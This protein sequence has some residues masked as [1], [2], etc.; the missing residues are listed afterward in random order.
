MTHWWAQT[1]EYLRCGDTKGGGPD[2]VVGTNAGVFGCGDTTCG[3]HDTVVGTNGKVF[4]V[5]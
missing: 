4:A 3:G 5:W 1:E 2:T